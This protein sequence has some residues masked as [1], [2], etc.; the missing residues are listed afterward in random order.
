MA[1]YQ[2]TLTNTEYGTDPAKTEICWFSTKEDTNF[3]ETSGFYEVESNQLT[4][5]KSGAEDNGD[6]S[7]K[8]AAPVATACVAI[9]GQASA[10]FVFVNGTLYDLSA[11]S[12]SELTTI[13]YIEEDGKTGDFGENSTFFSRAMIQS[14]AVGNFNGN[15]AGREQVYCTI[16]GQN[17]TSDDNYCYYVC[18]IYGTE[19]QDLDSA[20]KVTTVAD[21]IVQYGT[22]KNYDS[23]DSDNF[24]GNRGKSFGSANEK[25]LSCNVVAIDNDNDGVKAKYL[26][27][28]TT[29]TDPQVTAVLQAAPWFSELLQQAVQSV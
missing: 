18:S 19:Y 5:N 12:A 1:G 24:W 15:D 7:D 29:Y 9:N 27:R 21:N 2:K 6:K 25:R 17:D 10:E 8:A 26:G 28:Q 20:G 3:Y 13:S 14:V 23:S 4:A 22:A 16:G 11:G